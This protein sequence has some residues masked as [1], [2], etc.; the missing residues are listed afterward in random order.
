M[1]TFRNRFRSVLSKDTCNFTQYCQYRSKSISKY[2]KYFTKKPSK[3]N[4]FNMF[5]Q[6]YYASSI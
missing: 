5:K 2:I 3:Q 4:E 1:V 6:T